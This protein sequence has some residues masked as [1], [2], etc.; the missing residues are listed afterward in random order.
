MGAADSKEGEGAQAKAEV[1]GCSQM[2]V[3]VWFGRIGESRIADRSRRSAGLRVQ[4]RSADRYVI[5]LMTSFTAVH[6]PPAPTHDLYAG[7]KTLALLKIQP[8]LALRLTGQPDGR[9]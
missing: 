8:Q 5:Y 4:L 3:L 1:D 2:T 7:T 9:V 6:P